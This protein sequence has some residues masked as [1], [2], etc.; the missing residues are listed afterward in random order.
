M[1]AQVKISPGRQAREFRKARIK[2]LLGIVK[3]KK[4]WKDAFFL[5]YPEFDTAK[6][7]GIINNGFVGK[8][9]DPDLLAALEVWIPKIQLEK[10]DWF[11][12]SENLDQA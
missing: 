6:G 9:N 5:G 3:G 4:G 11:T 12:K 8:T 2:Y 10:P 1:D 7:N